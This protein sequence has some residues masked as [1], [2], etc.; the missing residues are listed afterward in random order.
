MYF[1]LYNVTKLNIRLKLFKN[2]NIELILGYH[3]LLKNK[4]ERIKIK[5]LKEN[6]IIF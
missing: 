1:E 3:T 4:L 5:F 2:V 6:N